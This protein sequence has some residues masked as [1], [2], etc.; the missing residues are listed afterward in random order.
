M[1]PFEI[2]NLF[3]ITGHPGLWRMRRYIEKSFMGNFANLLDD[4]KT[5][6]VK[7]DKVS[8]LDNIEVYTDGGKKKLEDVI[9]YI[10]EV[11][12]KEPLPE[13]FSALSDSDRTLWMTKLVPGYD[14]SAFKP[15]HMDK[16]LKWYKDIMAAIAILNEGLED[17]EQA[18]LN[19]QNKNSNEETKNDSPASDVTADVTGGTAGL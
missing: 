13:D 7:L 3:A 19:E 10:M 15:Y 11:A 1:E 4:F 14:V 9:G 8:K 16:I 5:V 18:V 2:K 17:P 12:E 6:T